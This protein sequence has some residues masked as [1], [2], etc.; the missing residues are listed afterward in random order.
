MRLAIPITILSFIG[1]LGGCVATGPPPP[2][3]PAG[4]PPK[5]PTTAYI[6]ELNYEVVDSLLT[7]KVY[8]DGRLK[9]LGHNHVIST[10]AVGGLISERRAD[11]FVA[12]ATFNVDDPELRSAAGAGFTSAP[13]PADIEATRRNMLGPKLLDAARYPYVR[14]RIDLPGDMP[15]IAQLEIRVKDHTTSILVPFQSRQTEQTLEIEAKFQL[16]HQQLDLT[17]FAALGGA[18][19]VADQMDLTLKLTARNS[20]N[21]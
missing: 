2:E 19:T 7:V 21:R 20:E 4:A 14:M 17:P 15:G 3:P 8:R 11:L 5:F 1:L 18:I 12:V 16:D 6:D 10:T 9:R 13:K